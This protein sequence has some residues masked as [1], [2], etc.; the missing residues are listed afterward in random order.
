MFGARNAMREGRDD[1]PLEGCEDSPYQ[2]GRGEPMNRACA[3]SS[4]YQ[5]ARG[6]LLSHRG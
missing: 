5:A 4:N 2:L 3:P 6:D 1:A